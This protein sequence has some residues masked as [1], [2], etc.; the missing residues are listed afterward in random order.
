[1][2]YFELIFYWGQDVDYYVFKYLFFPIL[3]FDSNYIHTRLLDIVAQISEGLFFH[4][5]VSVLQTE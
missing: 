2:T 5:F 1:M 4:F 3:F